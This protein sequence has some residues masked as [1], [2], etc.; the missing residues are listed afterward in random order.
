VIAFMVSFFYQSGCLPAIIVAKT[1]VSCWSDSWAMRRS[2]LCFL[3]L[4]TKPFQFLASLLQ[5][6]ARGVCL[7]V[8]HHCQQHAAG[9]FG[10]R[11]GV[12]MVEIVADVRCQ[13]AETVDWQIWPDAP[14]ELTGANIT[15]LRSG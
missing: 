12:V 7:R 3:G 14:G 15:K 1:P 10:I 6:F 4:V 9:G 8:L 2:G 11:L 13:I 5:Q